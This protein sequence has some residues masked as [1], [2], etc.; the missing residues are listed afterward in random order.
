M[1][2]LL[3]SLLLLSSCT[4]VDHSYREPGWPDDI[5]VFEHYVSHKEMRNKCMKYTPIGM[6]PMACAEWDLEIKECHIWFS[7]DF[8][9]SKTIIEHER[10]HC[11]GYIRHDN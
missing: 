6:D 11:K 5:R 4:T 2:W 8:L 1:K 10:A 3:S 9:P 7:E